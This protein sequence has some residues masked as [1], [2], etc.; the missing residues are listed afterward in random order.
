MRIADDLLRCLGRVCGETG[1][2]WPLAEWIASQDE[3]EWSR[4][5]ASAI[6]QGSAGA[7]LERSLSLAI[8]VQRT[9]LPDRFWVLQDVFQR[10]QACAN[11]TRAAN[12]MPTALLRWLMEH[13][14]QAASGDERQVLSVGMQTQFQ[15]TA[16]RYRP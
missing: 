2:G 14:I 12:G 13:G 7:D 4:I 11:D 15:Y 5:R 1:F 9:C 10:W 3:S 8:P 6:P 16:R